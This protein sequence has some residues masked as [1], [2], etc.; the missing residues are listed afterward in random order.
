MYCLFWMSS[1]VLVE[2]LQ[3]RYLTGKDCVQTA[4]LE[5]RYSEYSLVAFLC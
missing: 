1:L 2:K 3:G 5:L 4:L